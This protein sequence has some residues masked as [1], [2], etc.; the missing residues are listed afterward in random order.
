MA[1]NLIKISVRHLVGFVL[2]S[3][4]LGGGGFG[5]SNRLVE[6]TRGHQRIQK[7]RPEGYQIEVPVKHLVEV[8][9]LGLEIN[10][11]IDG[12]MEDEGQI[13]VE[14][15]KTTES[16]LDSE[17]PDNAAH[18]AQAKVY[19]YIL[20]VQNDLDEVSVQL[21]YVQLGTF[22]TLEDRR[23]FDLDELDQFFADMVERY[24]E[25]AR[26]Y[27]EWCPVRDQSIATV[28][29]PYPEY[30]PGQRHMAVAAYR[31]IEARGRLFAQ[32]PTGIGKTV[33][34]LF[35][36]IKAMGQGHVEKIFYLT[37]KTVGRTVAEKALDDLRQGGLR[38]KSLTLTA[39]DRICFN[40][41]GGRSCDP[42]QCEF[43]IGYYDRVNDAL[44]AIFEADDFTRQRI[45]EVARQYQV[46]P[47]EFSLDLSLWAD[48]I[49][50]DYNYVFD[51]RA[52]LKRFFLDNS[53]DYVFLIDEAHNLVDRAREMFSARLDRLTVL[54]LRRQVKADHATLG[55]R[56]ERINTCMRDMGK[57][58][59]EGP[60]GAHW[61][62]KEAPFRLVDL[63]ERFTDEA[64]EVL[65]RNTPSPY[66][67]DLLEFYFEAVA[68]GNI[69]EL[70]D[71]RYVTYVEKEDRDVMV[72]LFCLDPSELIRQ[73]LKRGIA[74]VFF[75]A[76]LT[77]L[78]YFRE[79]LGG[80]EEDRLLGLDSP[81]PRQHLH[82]LVADHIGTTYKARQHSYGD[83]AEAIGQAAG[84]RRGNYLAF[85]PSYRYME[86][87][88]ERFGQ[89]YPGVEVLV[90]KSGMSESERDDFLAVFAADN[91]DTM[92]GFAV[93]GGI[94]GEGIDLV[95]ERLVGAFIV[96]V[97]LPQVGLERNLIRSYF[98]EQG[99]DGF[100]YAYTF[101]GMNRV[102][103]AAG[104]VIRSAEDKGVVLLIDQ[105]FG[106]RRYQRLFPPFWHGAL[107][108]RS[109][110][111]VAKAVEVFWQE[112]D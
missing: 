73:A 57:R 28:D 96:G 55:R 82:L 59:E 7:S 40:P 31:T 17:R 110:E 85:F 6:G 19:A 101:P 62:D 2:R 36:T 104:R 51:P 34:S 50:C 72:R 33:S 69:A 89:V 47:F 106:Q 58:C 98:D 27:H 91:D 61:V 14:E 109:A 86:E 11:R 53:G 29:F 35:P 46:C 43:A 97:G 3:G 65:A 88:A 45:E 37:A 5:S 39:R 23:R 15:I 12:L 84:Q 111:G 75:S 10:G 42:E 44:K 54:G 90:Q 108:A 93:M 99:R 67:E 76:T 30:R 4:S 26:I 70:Y 100:E 16:E 52:Y 32:A 74:A 77:P 80:E 49:I 64:E 102:L 60:E 81:F 24:L 87:V 9:G 48:A 112:V 107:R 25:W 79:I 103:Q 83:V 41:M 18:W 21:T 78:P 94:F 68:F 56:L 1:A 71:E 66:F 95:G 20:A 22:E 105:R 13:V 38:L 92:V 8:E 63:V